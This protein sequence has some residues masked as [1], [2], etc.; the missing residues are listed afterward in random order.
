M[1]TTRASVS[2][3][4]AAVR[5]QL[6]REARAAAGSNNL[7][8]K[9]EEQKLKDGLLKSAAAQVRAEGGPGATVTVD[10]FVEAVAAKLTEAIGRVNQAAGPGAAVLSQA[11]VKA[12]AAY[13]KDVAARVAQAYEVVTGTPVKLDD[14][15]PARPVDPIVPPRPSV[16]GDLHQV[17]PRAL[18]LVTD[19]FARHAG[20]NGVFN[21]AERSSLPVAFLRDA[22]IATA[23]PRS[24]ANVAA[25]AFS[26]AIEPLLAQ[27][28]AGPGS[29][30]TDPRPLTEAHLVE[31]VGRHQD[32]AG[33]LADAVM[34]LTGQRPNVLGLA[35]IRFLGPPGPPP[36]QPPA[37]PP[38][39]VTPGPPPPSG[40]RVLHNVPGATGVVTLIDPAQVD[41]LMR[42]LEKVVPL[43]DLDRTGTVSLRDAQSFVRK[44]NG[45]FLPPDS[46]SGS[47]TQTEHAS[48][49]IYF[50]REE[51]Y[52]RTRSDPAPAQILSELRT[53]ANRVKAL[54]TDERNT[55]FDRAGPRTYPPQAIVP[56]LFDAAR[57][58]D[59]QL[60]SYPW[61]GLIDHEGD[62]EPAKRRALDLSGPPREAVRELVFQFNKAGND[63]HW[64]AWSGRPTSRYRLDVDEVTP[65]VARLEQEPVARQRELF[66][67]LVEWLQS[68][69]PGMVYV[70]IPARP[71]IDALAARLGH[72]YRSPQGDWPAPRLPP[73]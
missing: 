54:G 32:I 51:V 46:N 21:E 49:A 35:P 34:H 60:H 48:R 50:A 10:R 23:T 8:S 53:F 22:A 12:L 58:L 41:E 62:L 3:I 68:T 27:V 63:N 19:V 70:N 17:L 31:L 73:P 40:A 42:T 56:A 14:A 66:S 7:L 4:L 61:L 52:R 25:T 24:V 55:L 71:L 2:T 65:L 39:P 6:E 9:A 26:T 69:S 36:L 45:G 28:G 18:E 67:A 29:R 16:V 13:D 5:S 43:M 1:T 37:P 33:L 72:P 38:A 57:S 59:I 64:P 47:W 11:E 15:A 44:L 30:S 20:P